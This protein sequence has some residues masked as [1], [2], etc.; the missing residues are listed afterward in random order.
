MNKR[1][2]TNP[3]AMKEALAR[4]TGMLPRES[5]AL[6][7][8]ELKKPLHPA[9]RLNR[10]KVEPQA[11]I[12]NW[13][14]SYGWCV[15]QVPY[16]DEG[17]WITHYEKPISQ[18]V[19]HRLGSY[20]IQDAASMLPVSLFDIQ[21]EAHPLI[22]DMA[23]SP[24]GKTTHLIDRSRDLGL[25][26]ANDSSRDRITMLRLVLQNW[27][28]MNTAV[29][30]FPGE[31][32]GEWFPNTFDFV[33]LDAPCS[34][35]NLRSTEARPMHAISPKER[36][37]LAIRQERLLTSALQAVREGG[38][39]VYATCTLNPEENEAVLDAVLTAQPGSIEIID[40]S[41]RLVKPAPGLT[42]VTLD[43]IDHTFSS[44]VGNAA[45]FWPHIYATSGFFAA[46]I[47]KTGPIQGKT[48]RPPFLPLNRSA[49]RQFSRDEQHELF[50]TFLQTYGFDF[51]PVMDEQ[52]LSLW[53]RK[54]VIY[55][56]PEMWW[57]TFPGF[58]FQAVGMRVADDSKL[59]TPSHE[60]V[61]RFGSQFQRNVLNLPR[62]EQDAWL[63]GEDLQ[64]SLPSTYKKGS[65]LVLKDEENR[66]FG[67]G[68]V[69]ANRVR[70]LLP[71]RLVNFV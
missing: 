69:L 29:T 22:L 16:C 19:E 18:P 62:E 60:W 12:M 33:L 30:R 64:L 42:E 14:E 1:F 71:S 25:V 6:L 41:D 58:P 27:G 37:L 38:Q 46:L 7:L 31:K 15:E 65:I 40:I 48:T 49:L 24:G 39:V 52:Q 43:G 47:R 11:A 26:I 21:T 55:A 5:F 68:K 20:Y 50:D 54:E 51:K 13:A 10:L 4:F 44:Q 67:R 63:R 28:T 61:A 57:E 66:L 36:S 59:I 70:N 2:E 23:A 35:Q 3:D 53:R 8:E 9:I 17:W 34:M 56:I 32:Y 45:R